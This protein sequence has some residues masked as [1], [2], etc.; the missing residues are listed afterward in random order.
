MKYQVLLSLKKILIQYSRLSSAAVVIGALWVKS[1]SYQYQYSYFSV[2]V[3]EKKVYE[4]KYINLTDGQNVY[5]LKI[6]NTH[7]SLRKSADPYYIEGAV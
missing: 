1:R 4:N 6:W 3:I 7:V 5:T 2:F